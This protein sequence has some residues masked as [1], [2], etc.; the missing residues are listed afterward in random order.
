MGKSDADGDVLAAVDADLP[1]FLN[2]KIRFTCKLSI[3]PVQ[4]RFI[5]GKIV[6]CTGIVSDKSMIQLAIDFADV[7]P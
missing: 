5:I 7:K 4:G 1:L 6:N 2:T 3:I